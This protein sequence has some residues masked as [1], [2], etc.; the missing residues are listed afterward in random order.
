MQ[1]K[2]PIE[3]QDEEEYSAKHAICAYIAD[4]LEVT[5]GSG[6]EDAL[7]FTEI[8][9]TSL[10]DSARP[11]FIFRFFSSYEAPSPELPTWV[12]DIARVAEE[13]FRELGWKKVPK[14]S[15]YL[16]NTTPLSEDEDY[17]RVR[18]LPKGM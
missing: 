1:A 14:P 7:R 18:K 6:P 16:D 3:L 12:C 2:L 11:L 8:F 5:A 17:N 10:V 13:I 9:S 4:Q 15:W